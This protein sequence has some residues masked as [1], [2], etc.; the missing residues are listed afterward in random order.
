MSSARLYGALTPVIGRVS[1]REI[2]ADFEEGTCSLTGYRLLY[3]LEER[4]TCEMVGHFF[5]FRGFRRIWKFKIFR[6]INQISPFHVS[7]SHY[8]LTRALSWPALLGS[9]TLLELKL[10][11][12]LSGTSAFPTIPLQVLKTSSY[13]VKEALWLSHLAFSNRT[14]FH[15]PYNY[16]AS[17]IYFLKYS[18]LIMLC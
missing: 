8:F 16:Y 1:R 10:F 17:H 15:Y 11:W 5:R 9:L 2:Q 12:W 7:W 18:W 6:N 4:G 13:A 3:C 14:Q